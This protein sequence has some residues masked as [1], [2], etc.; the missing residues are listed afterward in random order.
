[1]HNNDLNSG[2]S[3]NTRFQFSYSNNKYGYNNASGTFVPFENSSD[4]T[5]S[6]SEILSGFTAYVNG[7]KITGNYV[8]PASYNN[9]NVSIAY[10]DVQTNKQISDTQIIKGSTITSVS[11]NKGNTDYSF[12]PNINIS[13]ACYIK[14]IYLYINTFFQVDLGFKTAGI[15]YN[16]NYSSGNIY[17]GIDAIF[18]ITTY[19]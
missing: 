12:A 7:N 17:N 18:V 15:H 10:C 11:L 9:I 16:P 5:A 8:A 3:N 4:A 14:M 19:N 2:D 1:M 6:A 13:N